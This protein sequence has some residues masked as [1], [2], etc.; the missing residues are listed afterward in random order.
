MEK[1]R[2][3]DT[4]AYI[5]RLLVM[6]RKIEGIDSDIKSLTANLYNHKPNLSALKDEFRKAGLV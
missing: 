3:R 1:Y 4:Y 6:A 2:S 5:A